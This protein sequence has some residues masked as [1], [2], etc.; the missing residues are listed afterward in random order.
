MR[1]SLGKC[2]RTISRSDKG[3]GST[4]VWSVGILLSI[5]LK[6]QVDGDITE[7]LVRIFFALNLA[8]I[9]VEWY[10]WPY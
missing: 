1:D 3:L 4:R 8:S 2:Y 9:N 5:I 6:F 7:M 10:H